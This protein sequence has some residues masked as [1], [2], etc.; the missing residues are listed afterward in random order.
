MVSI[1]KVTP[2]RTRG[3][4]VKGSTKDGYR[5]CAKISDRPSRFG[6]PTREEE[7]GGRVFILEVRDEDGRMVYEYNGRFGLRTDEG[8]DVAFEV[9]DV[10]EA[11]LDME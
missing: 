4:W 1:E 2:S 8:E 9:V 6:L 10:I 11:V 7:G 3:R 5:F